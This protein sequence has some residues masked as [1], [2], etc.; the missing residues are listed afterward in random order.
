MLREKSPVHTASTVWFLWVVRRPS[1]SAARWL[2]P[3][4][5]LLMQEAGWSVHACVV[6]DQPVDG[7]SAA[8]FEAWSTHMQPGGDSAPI[9]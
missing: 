5:S 2:V 3:L 4:A 8:F 1:V 7:E 6:E 9:Q